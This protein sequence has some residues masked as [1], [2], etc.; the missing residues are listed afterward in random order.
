[1]SKTKYTT[2]SSHPNNVNPHF[3]T[4]FCD[5]ESCF[6]LI[7]SKNPRYT[8]GWSV[9]LVFNIHLHSKDLDLLY[10]IQRFFCVGN[11]TLHGDAAVY[12]AT[13][14]SD[15]ARIIEHFN[16]YP[17]KTQKYADFL[18]LKKAFDIVHSKEHLTKDGLTK[19]VSLRACLNKGLPER[20]EAA[21]PNVTPVS[22]P[23]V[24]KT[25]FESN[26]LELNYWMAGFVTGEGCFF[27]K[28]SKS[29]TH[30]LGISVTLNFI[31]VQNVRDAFLIESFVDFF[32]C[33]S[34]SIAEKSGIARFSVSNFSKLVEIIIPIFEEYPVLGGK[35]ED[36]KDFKEVSVL[37]KSKAHLS[38][39]GLN[40]IL[41][42]KSKMNF[43]REF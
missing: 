38:N 6:T 23:P 25:T 15:L 33:G 4:G 3:V 40:K 28:T 35:A 18:L 26:K 30:K 43:K 7:I 29:K 2:Q 31:I 41:L 12:Q 9:K 21:F 20:L 42:I 27:V 16:N 11:V 5:A 19:L 34:F 17:L 24:P 32:C 39:E 10:L 13:K 8:L 36:F 22:R 37:I 1:M 14:L